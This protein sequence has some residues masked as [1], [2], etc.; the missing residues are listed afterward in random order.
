LQQWLADDLEAWF[1]GRILSV[2]RQVDNRWA[3]LLAS[4]HRLG[5]LLPAI[6]SL[7]A[8]TALAH[9]LTIVTRNVPDFSGIGATTINPWISVP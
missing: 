7:I 3:V 2:D 1:S 4:G 5:R 8:A 6:D 9:D